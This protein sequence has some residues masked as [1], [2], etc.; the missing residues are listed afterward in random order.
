MTLEEIS[1]IFCE[2]FCFFIIIFFTQITFHHLY[3]S[4]V[5]I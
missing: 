1:E 2:D 4:A 3:R 5:L